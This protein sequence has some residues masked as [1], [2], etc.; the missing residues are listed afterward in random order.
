MLGLPIGMLDTLHI[1]RESTVPVYQQIYDQI[2]F[3]I[4]AGK[5]P[6]GTRLPSS[7][8]LAGTIGLARSSVDKVYKLLEDGG[9]IRPHVG[10]GSF[11]IWRAHLD[12]EALLPSEDPAP[13]MPSAEVSFS[14]SRWSDAELP[15]E[16]FRETCREVT[17]S[18][19]ALNILQLGG[20]RGYGPLRRFVLEYLRERG[21]A[22]SEDDIL[23]TSGAQQAFDLIQRVLTP[24]GETVLMEDPVYPGLRNAFQRAGARV[25]GVPVGRDGIELA[26]LASAIE[27]ERPR[28][29]V[30]TP[31]FQNPTGATIPEAGRKEIL[32]MAQRAGAILLENDLYGPLRYTGQHVPPLKQLDPL[33][34]TIL[35]GSFSKIAFPGLR[36]GWAVGPRS[37]I[38]RMS[39]AKQACDLASDQLS[40]AVLLRFAE[41]GRLQALLCRMITAG[42]DRLD[43]CLHGL[44]RDLPPGSDFTRPEGGM[45]VWV[46]LPEPL[47]A[48]EL[49][50][51]AARENV[52]YLPGRY[53][54]VS[55]PHTNALRVC[56]CGSGTGADRCRFARF[57]RAVPQ[58]AVARKIGCR[59]GAGPGAGLGDR[60]VLCGRTACWRARLMWLVTGK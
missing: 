49:A 34:D 46:R 7:R 21:V 15:L 44:Q 30:V 1:D 33:S 5:I 52:S 36:V 54:S 38:A 35:V 17:A 58:R 16:D 60:V 27:R 45:N 8:E 42:T 11:V 59:C 56:L 41:S 4:K 19:E 26:A 9:F 31:D 55:R 6:Y 3:A 43:A 47:D 48:A 40:Q 10:R 12:W 29:V 24:H 2:A 14:A 13:P 32:E 18:K 37:F 39:E 22:G 57:G 53:F 50:V 20:P 23:I 51:R 28:L 25:V